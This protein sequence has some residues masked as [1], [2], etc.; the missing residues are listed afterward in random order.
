[1]NQKYLEYV[2]GAV[3]VALADICRTG[4]GQLAAFEESAMANTSRFKR[5]R[6]HTIDVGGRN[7]SQ[8]T[9][10][11]N[12]PETRARKK[13]FPPL[14]ELTYCTSSWRRA[15]GKLERHQES[16]IRY[17]YANDL[18]FEGQ[19]TICQYIWGELQQILKGKKITMKVRKRLESLVWLAVQQVAHKEGVLRGDEYSHTQLAELSGVGKSTWSETY[20]GHWNKLIYLVER[21]DAGSLQAIAEKR[22]EARSKLL[23][24]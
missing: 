7:V 24:S 19:V 8:E 18:N 16:W 10:P 11:V 3:S 22:I 1:M 17:C 2:R 5:K 21:L 9:D 15:V 4:K 23:A 20:S 12:C 14:D 13:P 6:I